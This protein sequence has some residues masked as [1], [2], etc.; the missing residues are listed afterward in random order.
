MIEQGL[1]G[2]LGYPGLIGAAILTAIIIIPIVS[3]TL[4]L[5]NAA[6]A[7]QRAAAPDSPLTISCPRCQ[8]IN[9][10]PLGA[11]RALCGSC[12]TELPI[13]APAPL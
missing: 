1:S 10:A 9:R 5:Q 6:L 12:Q 11:S 3:R 2:L 8:Q 4:Q 13:P 7:R